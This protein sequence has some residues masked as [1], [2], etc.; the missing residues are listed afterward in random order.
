M[1]SNLLG[2]RVEFTWY[3][4]VLR[5]RAFLA[6][7]EA[8]QFVVVGPP[9]Q[10]RASHLSSFLKSD[11]N[12]RSKVPKLHFQIT[13]RSSSGL[14][15]ML[16]RGPLARREKM[17]IHENGKNSGLQASFL[18]E[19]WSTFYSWWWLLRTIALSKSNE[20]FHSCQGRG[21]CATND[22]KCCFVRK[23]RFF[24]SVRKINAHVL[25]F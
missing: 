22:V 20:I 21:T 13:I 12:F 15:L 1:S 6:I 19:I 2:K 5:K 8:S 25:H 23:L 14:K 11:G 24:W 4:Q 7:F 9:S 16:L 10:F 18:G 3:F 17:T